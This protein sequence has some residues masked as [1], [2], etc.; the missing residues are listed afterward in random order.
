MGKLGELLSILSG[1]ITSLSADAFMS[2]ISDIRGHYNSSSNATVFK[3]VEDS[4]SFIF[5]GILMVYVL[6]QLMIAD[7]GL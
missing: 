4:L 1:I 7:D 5:D 6:A 2:N 3:W